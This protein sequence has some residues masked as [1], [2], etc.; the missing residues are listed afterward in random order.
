M[1]K[2]GFTVLKNKREQDIL[3]FAD[4]LLNGINPTGEQTPPDEATI[5]AGF[6]FR[7]DPVWCR[8]VS[9]IRQMMRALL[10]QT[11][12]AP[13]S[14]EDG[15]RLLVHLDGNPDIRITGTSGPDGGSITVTTAAPNG[16]YRCL[17]SELKAAREAAI[18]QAI[19]GD[20]SELERLR[21]RVWAEAVQTKEIQ[22]ML[23]HLALRYNLVPFENE[24]D[25]YT[26]KEVREMHQDVANYL[27]WGHVSL[28][29]HWPKTLLQ[30][31]KTGNGTERTILLLKW[32]GGTYKVKRGKQW[33]IGWWKDR[34]D[35]GITFVEN[36][37]EP[38]K[39]MTR[40]VRVRTWTVYY[41]TRRGGGVRTEAAA[42]DLWR[43]V[44][45]PRGDSFDARNYRGERKRLFRR[46]SLKSA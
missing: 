14:T 28:S 25:D 5:D 34:G 18:R 17:N 16:G 37:P 4:M 9:K 22:D 20:V 36:E 19:H 21:P 30:E 15:T 35:G 32:P 12:D 23:M 40:N 11:G 39:R 7:F 29:F 8:Q 45:A 41:L 38:P 27:I 6:L 42:I 26:P 2:Y 24:L 33:T 3:R 1:Y 10:G 13:L 31:I 46:G 43:E 44:F